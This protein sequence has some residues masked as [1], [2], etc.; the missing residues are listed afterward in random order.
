M[1][2]PQRKTIHHSESQENLNYNEKKNK[3]SYQHGKT[4][5][6]SKHVYQAQDVGCSSVGE[7][8]LGL[9]EILGSFSFYEKELLKEQRNR[10]P[11]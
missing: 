9:C 8:V 5:L 4:C 1:P 2:T 7:H 10:T 3:D 11:K 6:A